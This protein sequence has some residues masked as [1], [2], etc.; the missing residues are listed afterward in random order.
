MWKAKQPEHQSVE[1]GDGKPADTPPAVQPLTS[2]ETA[3]LADLEQIIDCGRRSFIGVGTALATIRDSKLYRQTHDTFEAYCKSR[4]QIG[5][6]HAYRQIEAAETLEILSPIGDKL[7]TTESQV[8]PLLQFVLQDRSAVWQ[9]VAK[10][11]PGERL[12]AGK[13]GE[14]VKWLIRD[15]QDQPFKQVRLAK[16]RKAKQQR[17]EWQKRED[18]KRLSRLTEPVVDLGERMLGVKRDIERA[19]ATLRPEHWPAL[20]ELLRK[21]ADDLAVRPRV[22]CP[23]CGCHEVDNDGDCSNC[24]EPGIVGKAESGD[25][26]EPAA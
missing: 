21:M 14:V 26:Q 2:D 5:R 19:A 11:L 23:N 12:T 8:R 6:A 22:I 16:K 7:P 24:Q 25:H 15:S 17:D 18:Q 20:V 3:L 9:V 13:I 1:T 4:W 10:Q